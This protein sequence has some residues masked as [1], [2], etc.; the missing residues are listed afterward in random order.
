MV[1]ALDLRSNGRLPAWVRTPLPV[2]TA[3]LSAVVLLEFIHPMKEYYFC[4]YLL[5]FIIHPGSTG[6]LP[7]FPRSPKHRAIVAPSSQAVVCQWVSTTVFSGF[8]HEENLS[9][10]ISFS[11]L[12]TFQEDWPNPCTCCLYGNVLRFSELCRPRI[13]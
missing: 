8:Q 9:T 3:R 11:E 5:T 6:W 4:I 10:S 1:K 12:L 2:C 7:Y 13:P